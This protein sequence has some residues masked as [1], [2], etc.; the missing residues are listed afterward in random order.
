MSA[1]EPKPWLQK[2]GRLIVFLLA[3][4]LTVFAFWWAPSRQERQESELEACK[5]QCAPLAGAIVGQRGLP[6]APPDARR[7]HSRFGKC[8]CN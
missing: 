7:N 2:Y 3:C 4:T 6:N 5:K 1:R 8:V